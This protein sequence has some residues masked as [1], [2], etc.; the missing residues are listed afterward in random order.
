MGLPTVGSPWLWVGFFVLIAGL[1]ALDLGVF[2]RRDRAVSTREALL[3]S[4]VWISLALL[5]N[6][7]IW[8][9]LGRKPA[10]EFLTGYVIEESLS[11]D[12]LFVF[13]T[14]FSFF[15][16]AEESQRRVLFFGVLGAFLLRGA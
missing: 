2:R 10:L 11:I 6:V 1:L 13:L 12:N 15:R 5:F 4:G 9:A 16:I 14:L 3:W 8:L 7:G